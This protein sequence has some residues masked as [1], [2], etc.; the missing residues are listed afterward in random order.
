M[1]TV[2]FYPGGAPAG[3]C[4]PNNGSG[5]PNSGNDP[6][7]DCRITMTVSNYQWFHFTPFLSGKYLGRPITVSLPA[8]SL[9]S[10]F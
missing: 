1:P 9:N 5:T 10:T 6:I 7:N 3:N 4:F 8:E 2:S